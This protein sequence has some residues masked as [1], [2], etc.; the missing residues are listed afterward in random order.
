M[1]EKEAVVKMGEDAR[2]AFQAPMVKIEY[3]GARGGRGDRRRRGV[4]G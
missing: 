2:I 1:G 3:G 4:C